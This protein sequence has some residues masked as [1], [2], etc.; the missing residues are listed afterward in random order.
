ML[1]DKISFVDLETSG[2]NPIYDRIIEIGILRVENNRIVKKF[3]TLV[4]PESHVPPFI[5]NM[6]GIDVKELEGAPTFYQI[7]D[8]V[9]EILADTVFVAHNVRFDYSFIRHEFKRHRIDYSSR[10]FC[11]VKLFRSLYPELP[12]HDLD[13]VISHF[14]LKCESRHRAFDDA[15]VLWDFYKKLQKK[16]EPETL[17]SH[18]QKALR[19]P[20]LPS[21]VKQI[22]I[23]TLPE[24]PGVYIFYGAQGAP[25]YVGKSINIKDRILSH[26]SSDQESTR[27]MDIARQL[28]HI[29]T[30]STAGE[31][32]A[33]ILES[34][35]VKEMQPLY[36]RQLRNRHLLHVLFKSETP[37]GYSSILAETLSQVPVDRIGEV[38]S[39]HRSPTQAKNVL[40]QLA[41]EFEL[42]PRLLGLEK[43]SGACFASH[44]EKCRGACTGQEVP[45]KYNLRFTQ[46]FSPHRLKPWPFSGPVVIT[47][48]SPF[49]KGSQSF[50]V[51]KWCLISQAVSE[52]DITNDQL[53]PAEFDLDVYRILYNF[54]TNPRNQS[55]IKP[56]TY[57]YSRLPSQERHAYSQSFGS[58]I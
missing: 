52:E 13:A 27:E 6:T 17:L 54:L 45:L 12:H 46:A 34:R 35:L 51:D 26:F 9:Q 57:G 16:V 11:T 36:N 37:Q 28:C 47:E 19:R 50:V 43:G 41:A 40:R 10:H 48:S 29:E 18:I 22:E 39:I 56:F 20:S 30:R 1:P 7:K 3:K 32:S 42:C 31:L 53:E 14:N 49:F 44:L 21:G 5:A 8:E 24:T 2:S 58:E 4:N 23:D 38:L 15:K 55:S 25:L 33:L